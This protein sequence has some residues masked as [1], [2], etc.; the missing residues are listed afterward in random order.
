MKAP[1]NPMGNIQAGGDDDASF[2]KF[3]QRLAAFQ[4][5]KGRRPYWLK[6]E[7]AE[8]LSKTHD[9][10]PHPDINIHDLR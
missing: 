1:E 7:D 10:M 9:L 3:Q 6:P 8:A 2:L 5:L 4:H